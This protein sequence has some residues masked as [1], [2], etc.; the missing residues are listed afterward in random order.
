[1]T[2]SVGSLMLHLEDGGCPGIQQQVF[3]DHVNHKHIITNLLHPGSTKNLMS[4]RAED[5]TENTTNATS[6]AASEA[7]GGVGI[8]DLMSNGA[9]DTSA[10]GSPNTTHSSSSNVW[11]TLQPEK[12]PTTDT[13]SKISKGVSTMS[14]VDYESSDDETD[15][16]TVPSISPNVKANLAPSTSQ[17]PAAFAAALQHRQSVYNQQRPDTSR[18]ASIH[19]G[20]NIHPVGH[21]A[22]EIGKKPLPGNKFNTR[23][24]SPRSEYW[25]VENFFN[26]VINRY[27]CPHPGCEW[28]DPLSFLFQLTQRLVL[29][30]EAA[31]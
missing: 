18:Q 25:D 22:E 2:Q 9:D 10:W 8:W 29:T 16:T 14:L 31:G 5:D 20:A 17:K 6:D 3:H 13:F 30:K 24:W 27:E 19:A 28:V 15:G 4:V 21:Q 7:G 12:T 26:T 11:N 23:Y 1:M